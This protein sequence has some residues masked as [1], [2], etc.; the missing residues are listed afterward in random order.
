MLRA[1]KGT[2]NTAGGHSFM[3]HASEEE[4]VVLFRAGDQ[5]AFAELVRRH[6][7]YLMVIARRFAFSREEAEDIAQDALLR[8]MKAAQSYRGECAFRSWLHTVVMHTGY[9]SLRRHN[10]YTQTVCGE[11]AV[12]SE[13]NPRLGHDPFSELD[14]S[15]EVRAALDKLPPEQRAA[16]LAVD[17]AGHD[18]STVA[19]AWGVQPGTIKSRRF[20]ARRA[21]ERELA[22]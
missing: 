20:R 5:D 16:L 3:H 1:M 17:V 9:D 8:V 15:H 19:Q 10:R 7:G 21:L 22:A 12:D 11:V 4:L 2:A 13:I 14:H 6:H 18:V